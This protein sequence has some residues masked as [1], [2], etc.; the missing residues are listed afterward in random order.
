V[1]ARQA[2][3]VEGRRVE[4]SNLDKAMYPAVGFTKA[5]VVD[6]YTRVAPAILPHLADRPVTRVRFPNGVEGKSFFEKQCPDH[7]PDWVATVTVPVRGTG[8]FGGQGRGPRD[9]D[10]CLVEELPTLVWLANLA[11]LELHTSLARAEDMNAPTLMVLDLDPGPPAGLVECA[12]VGLW[13]REL[14]DQLGL[15]CVTKTS[16]KKGLQ[17]YVPLNTPVTYAETKPF[18]QAVAR[19]LEAE[20]PDM[21]VSKMKKELRGGKVFV[22]WQQNVDFKTTVCA[23]SLRAQERPTAST[24]VSWEEVAQAAEREDPELLVFDAPAVL[25]RVEREGDLFAPALELKQEL[26]QLTAPKR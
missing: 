9:V 11:A 15:V 23:Y 7:R 4:L 1:P 3:D 22:D 12:R 21:V 19:H 16:G 8:R 2:V 26:P 18:A 24:P 13:V 20:H 14:L 5:H 10:F 17:V 25:E 6:Y